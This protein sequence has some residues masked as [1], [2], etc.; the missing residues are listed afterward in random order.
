MPN[1]HSKDSIQ[2]I[3]RLPENTRK[4]FDATICYKNKEN[5]GANFTANSIIRA[6]IKKYVDDSIKEAPEIIW[7]IVDDI[8]NSIKEGKYVAKPNVLLWAGA[9]VIV[10]PDT[11]ENRK[12]QANQSDGF[13]SYN[14]T[15]VFSKHAREISALIYDLKELFQ[16]KFDCYSK[17]EFYGRLAEA[18]NRYLEKVTDDMGVLLAML[19]EINVMKKEGK[20]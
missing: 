20:L 10:L 13:Y 18:A 1:V 14:D 4:L 9:E 11:E 16:T 3:V 17:F 12:R 7:S 6:L 5:P 2:M 8:R 15:Y 19:D